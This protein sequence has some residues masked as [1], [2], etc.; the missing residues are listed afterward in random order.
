MRSEEFRV[1]WAAHDVQYYRSGVQPFRHPL[2]G[3]LVLSY[4]ALELPADPGQT[5]IA[6]TAEPGSAAYDALN[7]LASWTTAKQDQPTVDQA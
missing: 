6:Y 1:R 4:D 3:D 7:L 5:I 2:V